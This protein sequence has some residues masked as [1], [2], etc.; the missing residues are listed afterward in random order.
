VNSTE[1]NDLWTGLIQVG[2]CSL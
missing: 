2:R 1:V